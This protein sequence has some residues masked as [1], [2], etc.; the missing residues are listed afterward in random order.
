MLQKFVFDVHAC[1]ELIR[2][3]HSNRS[4]GVRDGRNMFRNNL[5][6]NELQLM[7]GNVTYWQNEAGCI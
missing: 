5:I 6:E 1:Q 3:R 4:V 7:L 2:L